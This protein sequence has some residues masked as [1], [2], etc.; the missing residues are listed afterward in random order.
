M[1]IQDNVGEE[2]EFTD[3]EMNMWLDICFLQTTRIVHFY[4]WTE[5]WNAFHI[6]NCVYNYDYLIRSITFL[7]NAEQKCATWRGR[8]IIG[9]FLIRYFL[10]TSQ[11]VVVLSS[12]SNLCLY[13][14]MTHLLMLDT[15]K[16]D[17][18][19]VDKRVILLI[20]YSSAYI[21]IRPICIKLQICDNQQAWINWKELIG[22]F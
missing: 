17:C 7:H 11:F 18:P 21:L 19:E 2:I 8:N 3:I 20:S 12:W 9:V 14:W 4:D 22:R 13:F 5:V 6:W 10:L 16:D 15:K 1:N